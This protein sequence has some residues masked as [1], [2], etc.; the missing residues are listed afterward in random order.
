MSVPDVTG[1]LLAAGAS[2]GQPA[3]LRAAGGLTLVREGRSTLLDTGGLAVS[4]RLSGVARRLTLPD[5]AV[6]VTA[7][8][9]GLEALL[10]AAGVRVG[11]R[12]I[13]FLEAMRPRLIAVV[14]LLVAAILV[15]MRWGLPIAAD[16]AATLVPHGIEVAMG[17]NSLDILDA[18]ALQPSQLHAERAAETQVLFAELRRAA[19]AAPDLRLENREG[20]LIGANALALP[21]GPI[22]VTDELVDL[23]PST[24]ALAGVLAHEIAHVEEQHGLRRLMRA[25]GMALIITVA[26]GDSGDLVEEAAGLPALLMDRAYSRNF[27]AEADDG[28]VAIMRKAGRDPAALADMLA[29][30]DAK[31]AAA[32]TEERQDWLASHPATADRIARLRGEALR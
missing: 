17:A 6:F 5:G 31:G 19:G 20:F 16:A 12:R 23:A 3:T 21:G 15:S 29:A 11:G 14:T 32:D 9:D 27:E 26:I 22:I 30:L 7:D 4:H 18:V 8:D 10:A 28:A 13:A 25:V 2:R 24:D 1:E